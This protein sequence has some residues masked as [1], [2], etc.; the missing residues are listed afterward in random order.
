MV[1]YRLPI[2]SVGDARKYGFQVGD[3][4]NENLVKLVRSQL[5]KES[6]DIPIYGNGTWFCDGQK[7]D[8]SIF[9]DR[10]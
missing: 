9:R 3:Y 4:I 1:E 5:M 7:T 10:F 2:K 6:L 8:L